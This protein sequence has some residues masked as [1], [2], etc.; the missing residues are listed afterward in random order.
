MA[1][2]DLSGVFRTLGEKLKAG[3]NSPN[4]Y[5]YKPHEKQIQFHKSTKKRRLYI[6]G[7]RSGK[8]V[9]G[10]V[11]DC[12]WLR[13][14]HPYRALPISESEPTRGRVI[15]V[16]LLQGLNQIILPAFAKWLPVGDLVNGSWEDSYNKSERVLRL[17]NGSYT[18]FLT[19][20]MDLEKF[21]G[22]SRHFIHADEEPPEGIY[23]ENTARLIDTGGSLW[24]TMT[25]V[26]GMTWVYEQ[27]YEPGIVGSDLIDVITVDM[28]E[29][30]YI[31]PS[32]V[33]L[34]LDGL[35][36][37]EREARGHGKFVQMGG[38]IYKHFDPKP[39]GKHVLDT[40]KFEIPRDWLIIASL[41]HGFNNPTAWLWHAVSPD[42]RVVTFHEH[43]KS[44]MVVEQHAAE[45]HRFNKTLGRTPDYYIGDPSIR[46][47]DPITGTSIHQE[48]AKYGIPIVL[49]NND[50]KAGIQKVARF[51]NPR[52]NGQPL[53]SVTKS[54][55]FLVRE[56]TKY[57][58]KTYA[59]KKAQFQ[60]NAFDEPHKKDDHACDSLRYFLMS[61]PDFSGEFQARQD[62]LDQE[63]AAFEGLMKV[64]SEPLTA[65]PWGNLD[66]LPAGSDYAYGSV[67]TDWVIDEQLGADY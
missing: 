12:W 36:P 40:E 19:Y 20:E 60:H 9:G 13:K 2:D 26:E 45:V 29:N 61:R 3:A 34:F 58:W 14:Q 31:S 57:R 37:D 49:A 67:S 24:I 30:P 63:Y 23:T 15:T 1:N 35:E 46:N 56:L 27:L 66:R 21:A 25:P 53:W 51:M 43:Y 62:G 64:G 41:D 5:G 32:E 65:D 50:V 16:D 4:L 44:G 47:T 22:T 17:A 59:S 39:G 42:G 18:E 48:Y 33:A 6:G 52:A 7:N 28:A 38:L 8:T 54:C 11:E 55:T 10:V